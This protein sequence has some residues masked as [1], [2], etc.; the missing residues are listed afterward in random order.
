M[1]KKFEE[2]KK[3]RIA[4]EKVIQERKQRYE[5]D[6]AIMENSRDEFQKALKDLSDFQENECEHKWINPVLGING[7]RGTCAICGISDY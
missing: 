1:S 5:H 4:L 6:R 7:H 2:L 3:K